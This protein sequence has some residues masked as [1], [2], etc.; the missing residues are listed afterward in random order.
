LVM[1]LTRAGVEWDA[2]NYYLLAAVDFATSHHVGLL[3]SHHVTIANTAPNEIPPLIPLWYGQAI[4]IASIVHA[5]ANDVLRLVP[6]V[7]LVATWSAIRRVAR[8][9]L[10]P[11][12]ADGAALLFLLLPGVVNQ[13][14]VFALYVDLAMVFVFAALVAEL[15]EKNDELATYLR[16]GVLCTLALITK[17]SGPVLVGLLL[18]AVVAGKL[19]PRAAS[20]ALIAL[21]GLVLI[22]VAAKVGDFAAAGLTGR[23]VAI[24]VTFILALLTAATFRVL[25]F[26]RPAGALLAFIA[27]IPGALYVW[28]LA[29]LL[30]SP[31]GYYVPSWAHVQSPNFGWALAALLAANVYGWNQQLGLPQHYGAGLLLWWGLAPITNVL[32][33]V[34]AFFAIRRKH[35]VAGLVLIISLFYLAWLTVLNLI[36]FRHLL[37]VMALLPILA[38][39][40]IRTAIQPNASRAHWPFLGAAACSIPF[41]WLGQWP[42]AGFPRELMSWYSLDSGHAMTTD[43]LVVIALFASLVVVAYLTGRVADLTRIRA[44]MNGAVVPFALALVGVAALVVAHAVALSVAFLI[45]AV[46]I[47]IARRFPKFFERSATIVASVA[48]VVAGFEPVV[49]TA[50]TIGLRN[51]SAAAR[52]Q[53]YFG[54]YPALQELAGRQKSGTVF[55][56]SG[57]G[58]SWYTVGQVRRIDLA[59]ALDLGILR[60][61]LA[62][63]YSGDTTAALRRYGAEWGIMPAAGNPVGEELVGL[64]RGANL[65]GI[66]SLLDSTAAT[67]LPRGAWMLVHLLP[68]TSGPHGLRAQLEV[69]ADGRTLDAT[70]PTDFKKPVRAT[71]LRVRLE[72]A[73]QVAALTVRVEGS[74]APDDRYFEFSRALVR[75]GNTIELP[76]A[77]LARSVGRQ[78]PDFEAARQLTIQ[79]I[80]LDLRDAHRLLLGTLV[81]HSPRFAVD[82]GRSGAWRLAA[83]NSAFSMRADLAPLNFVGTISRRDPASDLLVFPAAQI[84]NGVGSRV[85]EIEIGLAASPACRPG[86][87]VKLAFAGLR[88]IMD[89][90]QTR[91]L[92]Q[93]LSLTR[94][95]QAGTIVRIPAQ[96]FFDSS[97]PREIQQDAVIERVSVEP[98]P[99]CLVGQEIA[100]KLHLQRD[101]GVASNGYQTSG[102]VTLSLTTPDPFA[103]GTAGARRQARLRAGSNQR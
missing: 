7:V 58:V 61:A 74:H 1:C 71:A 78:D 25:P 23:G 4:G 24:I 6:F 3:A 34:G 21:T 29:R 35:E 84:A 83:D 26:F 98:G 90:G 79:S 59:D 100:G 31:A 68:P 30:G 12:Y 9:Y 10:Q 91:P 99:H 2:V 48:I 64:M 88:T 28:R 80:M 22:A 41:M 38:A 36:D 73:A 103:W 44:V 66:S 8:A 46:V 49:A 94:P 102:F 32:A 15:V 13:I 16:I 52:S 95:A 57:Y 40:C 5:N 14:A 45:A 19:K 87:P 17:V 27:V 11:A 82:P 92:E 70:R 18:I 77:A 93:R 72:G 50:F 53:Y 47:E 81:W 101:G 51:D 75:P 96:D 89:T 65:P 42:Y 62:S 43:A 55:T 60:K 63:P 67:Q 37:P 20:M 33:L 85:D 97:F 39:Y 86:E 56:F 54:F 76:F 69:Q